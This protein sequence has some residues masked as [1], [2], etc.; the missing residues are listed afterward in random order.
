ML[1]IVI[2]MGCPA[3]IGPEIILKYFNSDAAQSVPVVVAGDIKILKYYAAKLDVHCSFAPWKAGD[4]LPREKKT[5]SVYET[6]RLANEFIQPGSFSKETSMAMVEAIT[7]SVKGIQQNIFSGICTC[8]ISKE[9][10]QLSGQH[11]PGHTE[12]LASLCNVKSQIMMMAGKTL[13]VTLATIHCAIAEVPS[14]LQSDTLVDLFQTTY[15]SLQTDFNISTP[16]MP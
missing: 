4:T 8:P 15:K 13:K 10:L 3:G 6:S 16:R 5:I 1:P 12:M 9:A 7:R 11:F 14:L 2:T